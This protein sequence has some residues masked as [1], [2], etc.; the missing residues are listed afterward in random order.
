MLAGALLLTPGFVTDAVGLLL[1]VPPLREVLRHWFAT[2]ILARGE[3][4][5]VVDGEE[6]YYRSGEGEGVIEADFEE[7]PPAPEDRDRPDRPGKPLRGPKR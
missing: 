6:V 1:F 3:T 4:R 7:V 5:I 2:R